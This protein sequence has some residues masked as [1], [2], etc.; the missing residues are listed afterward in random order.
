MK[1]FYLST[2]QTKIEP[3]EKIKEVIDLLLEVEEDRVHILYYSS[4]KPVIESF[5][6][7]SKQ[8]KVIEATLD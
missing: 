2:K 4:F 8:A 7:Y 6:N 3:N 5:K 1:T